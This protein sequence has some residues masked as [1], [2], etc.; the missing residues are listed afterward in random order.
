MG[1]LDGQVAV[2]LGAS[3]GIGRGIAIKLGEEGAIVYAGA[4]T[5]KKG[6]FRTVGPGEVQIPGTLEETVQE[7]RDSGGE[8][9]AVE[10]DAGDETSIEKLIGSAIEHHGRIDLLVCSLLPDDQFEGSF[11]E[12]PLSTWDD[13]FAIGP[14]AYYAA[15][16][17]AAPYMSKA[18]SGLM[19]FLSSPGGALDFYSAAYCVARA[20]TDRLAQAIDSE[21]RER[22]VTAISL[23]PSYIRTERVEQALAGNAVGFSLEPEIDLSKESNSPE[24]VGMTVARLTADPDQLAIGGSVQLLATLCARYGLHDIDGSEACLSRQL[25]EMVETTGTIAPSAYI[26]R[27]SE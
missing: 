19:V 8:A 27:S 5:L 18:G 15:A 21:L 26:K 23:W 11:W 2:V 14:R 16:R 12:L 20:A 17:I 24:L 10:C 3:R 9:V 6:A 22:G 25:R 4:R 13:Q 7:I 1:I